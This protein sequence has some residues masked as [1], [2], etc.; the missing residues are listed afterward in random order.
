MPRGSGVVTRESPSECSQIRPGF[1]LTSRSETQYTPV[2]H[3]EAFGHGYFSKRPAT[4]RRIQALAA[5][6]WMS[7]GV[8]I[9]A[10]PSGIGR[11]SPAGR[12]FNGIFLVSNSNDRAGRL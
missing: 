2:R 5:L 10:V 3:S 1:P 8:L 7:Y 11:Q 9:H 12:A 6:L 4:L